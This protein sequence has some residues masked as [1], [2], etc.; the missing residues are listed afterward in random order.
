M[1]GV[2]YSSLQVDSQ[3]KS[4][5]LVWG[6]AAVQNCSTFTVWAGWTLTITLSWWVTAPLTLS[7]YYYY[8]YYY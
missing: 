1:V 4:I 6:L 5:G 2:D 7:Q 8:Y 3:P